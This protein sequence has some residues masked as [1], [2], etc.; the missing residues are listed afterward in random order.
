MSVGKGPRSLFFDE[1]EHSKEGFYVCR[2]ERINRCCFDS[3][4]M[5]NE[6]EI[7]S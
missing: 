4:N 7:T 3:G 6:S 2:P 5:I 1:S